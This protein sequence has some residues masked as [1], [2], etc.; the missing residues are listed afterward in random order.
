MQGKRW[1]LLLSLGLSACAMTAS[2]IPHQQVIPVLEAPPTQPY[3]V[4]RHF[5]EVANLCRTVTGT[6]DISTVVEKVY[7]ETRADAI[8]NLEIRERQTLDQDIIEGL[9]NF[10]T[11]GLTRCR[12]TVIEGDAIRFGIEESNP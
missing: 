2:E 12:N 3:T 1:L 11:M 8:I 10:G 5:I 6:L 4:L 9:M 7:R